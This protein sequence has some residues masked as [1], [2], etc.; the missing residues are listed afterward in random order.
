MLRAI[1]DWANQDSTQDLNSRFESLFTKG[2]L[3]GGTLVPVTGQTKV[4]LQP[5][6]AM[7]FDG[8]LVVND[9]ATLIDITLDQTNIIAVHAKHLIGEAATLEI[10]SIEA[11]VFSGLVEKDYYVVFGMV[12]TASPATEIA[13]LDIS[14]SIREYQDKRTRDKVRGMVNSTSELPID[15]NFN[16]YGDMYV[17]NFGTG[18]A[19]NIYSWDGINWISITGAAAIAVALDLHQHNLDTTLYPSDPISEQGRLHLTNYQY[20]AALGSYGTP[21]YE[22]LTPYPFNKYVTQ[23]DPRIPTTDQSAALAGSD[24]SPSATNKYVTQ[25]YPIAAPTQLA[26]PNALGLITLYTS[27]H[28]PIYVGKGV[29]GSAN[30]YFSLMDGTLNRGYLNTSEVPITINA[31]YKQY[32]PTQILLNPSTDSY[33]DSYGFYWGPT[34]L[35]LGLAGGTADSACRLVYGK[36]QYLK[37]ADHGFPVLPTPTYEIISGTLLNK[38]A[39]IKGR[40][41]DEVVPTA[42]QNINL[43]SDIDNISAYIGSVLET[44]VVASNEDFIRLEPAYPTFEKNVGVDYEFAFRNSSQ[45]QFSYVSSTGLITYYSAVNLTGVTLGDLFIDAAGNKYEVDGIGTNSVNIKNIGLTTHPD[46]VRGAYPESVDTTPYACVDGS[47]IKRATGVLTFTNT[48]LVSYTYTLGV[49]QYGSAVNLSTVRVGDL[50][51]DGGGVKYLITVVNDPADSLT[52]V[53]TQTGL[54][55]LTIST[56]VGNKLDGS[57]WINN[58][59]RDLLL[60]EMKLSFGNEFVPIKR[61]VRKTDEFSKPDGQVAYGIVRSDNRFDPRIV[62]YG[63]WE[64]YKNSLGETYVRNT[65]G[66]ARFLVSGYFHQ[67]FLVMR[68]RSNTGS[69]AVSVNGVSDTV[70]NPSASTYVSSDVANLAGPKYQVVKLNSTSLSDIIPATLSCV[71]GVGSDSFDVY[72]I[73]F[74]R[75]STTAL[76][77]SG[78]AFE[79]ASIIRRE[80][81]DATIPIDVATYQSRGGR[82]IYAALNNSYTRVIGTLQ[83]MDSNGTPKGTWT[84]NVITITDSGGKLSSY[85][86][87]DIITVN[88]L[89][90]STVVEAK[91]CRITS[92]GTSSINVDVTPTSGGVDVN[93]THICSTDST[94]PLPT[95]EEQIARYV[96]PNDFINNTPTDL[97]YIHQSDRFVVGP[98]GLTVLSGQAVLVTDVN[99][100][101]STKAVQIQQGSSGSLRFSVLATRLDVL[102]VNNASATVYVSVDGSP[103]YPYSFANQVQRRTIFS[104]ARYQTHEV[105]ITAL[106]GNFSIAEMFL[107]GPKK[108]VF[109][110]FP[111]QVADLSQIAKYQPSKYVLEAPLARNVYPTGCVFREAS[112]NIS[113]INPS[114][115]TGNNWSV[116]TNY[117]KAPFYGQY[118][119]T[120]RENAYIEFYIFNTAFE[121]QYI[122]GPDHGYFNVFVDGVD[123]A[124]VSGATVVDAANNYVGGRV[125]GYSATYS[126]RNIGIYNLSAGYHKITAKIPSPRTTSFSGYRMAFTGFHEGNNNGYMFYGISGFGFYTSTVNIRKFNAIDSTL[127]DPT[128]QTEE[129]MAKSGKVNLNIG[130]T[131]LLVSLATPYLDTD[132]IVTPC[133][134][135]TVDTY[136]LYQSLI[137]IAQTSSSFT[138]AWNVPIP[139]GNYSVHYYTR[140]LDV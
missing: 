75:T 30:V 80:M 74:D 12:T 100:L 81:P 29:V 139:N 128:V 55:P 82:L 104:N 23:L 68:R 98:D 122:T 94:I 27:T 59:P 8:M 99:I 19:P 15:A 56:S 102:C 9:A 78:R 34:P 72:G 85:N 77:E 49:V 124:S 105:T 61:L 21:G 108:P 92:I 88:V 110:D 58:N 10:V 62:F 2:V 36:Q 134:V 79:S 93:L 1:L 16:L 97:K 28:G 73:I 43:R 50:F 136:P 117:A 123:L 32:T 95:E 33:V 140:T 76:F 47:I 70:V 39:N 24:G 4:S 90:G 3:T 96:L 127:L 87:N 48:G 18:N 69:I 86:V 42:E 5:F 112:S 57:T 121:L 20:T 103:S 52:I 6:S 118:I 11:S 53:S 64:N 89:S 137:L 106:T 135:N 126:R 17:V 13:D 40:G 109:T 67:A 116:A 22:P 133:L 38:I 91:I 101:T 26:L 31:V 44:N 25:E 66:N 130:T 14:Y 113:F 7:S 60:S 46:I 111:N 131:S 132:Y 107:F 71:V 45:T 119:S 138:L 37:N 129:T 120:D 41:F 35:Y 63:S 84:G 125:D 65:N 114:S 54:A 83:D 51:R 115:G